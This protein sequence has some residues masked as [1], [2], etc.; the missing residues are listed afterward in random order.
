M[1]VQKFFCHGK[2]RNFAATKKNGVPVSLPN[3]PSSSS[4]AM[5]TADSRM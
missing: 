4:L 5:E 2:I 1:Q 3:T